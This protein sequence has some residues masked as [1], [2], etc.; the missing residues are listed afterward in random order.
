M[1][2]IP[3]WI[4]TISTTFFAHLLNYFNYNKYSRTVIARAINNAKRKGKEKKII[5]TSKTVQSAQDT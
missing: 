4:R 2:T 5:T 3:A 1:T